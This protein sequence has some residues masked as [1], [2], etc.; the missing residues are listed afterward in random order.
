[1]FLYPR[2]NIKPTATFLWRLKP[3][4]LVFLNS[5]VSPDE[6]SEHIELLHAKHGVVCFGFITFL[7]FLVLLKFEDT[8]DLLLTLLLR[9]ELIDS[10]LNAREF[11]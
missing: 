9:N 10:R 4:A 7:F 8:G 1:M 2:Y 5:Y 3:P 6:M 11:R